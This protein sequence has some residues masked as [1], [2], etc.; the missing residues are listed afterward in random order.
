M[1]SN[2][3]IVKRSTKQSK[4]A[5]YILMYWNW[6]NR[7][8]C[9]GLQYSLPVL[10][11]FSIFLLTPNADAQVTKE[12]AELY[13]GRIHE[14]DDLYAIG[15]DKMSN[16]YVAGVSEN[17][18][19]GRDFVTVSYDPAGLR[20]WVKW[21]G[22]SPKSS[23]GAYD[24]AVDTPGNI[25]VTGVGGSY[26]GKSIDFV[27]VSYEGDGI[28]RWVAE[29]DGP[30][31]LADSARAITTGT[32]NKI[33]VTGNSE[34]SPW[35]LDY[36]TVAY[37]FDGTELWSA[38]YD[39]PLN[40]DDRAYDI[41]ADMYGNVYVTGKSMGCSTS[42]ICF[43]IVT[44]AYDS[45][46]R[47]IWEARF[48]GPAHGEDSVSEITVDNAGNVYVVGSICG[49]GTSSDFVTLCYDSVSGTLTWV[50]TYDSTYHDYDYA[51]GIVLD[52]A[53]NIYVTGLSRR[54]DTR[55]DIVTISYDSTGTQRWFQRYNDPYDSYDFGLDIAVGP[56]GTVLV[57]G[58]VSNSSRP[59][60]YPALL[61]YHPHTSALLWIVS[62]PLSGS[63]VYYEKLPNTI[64]V[65]DHNE[66]YMAARVYT[67]TGGWDILTVKCLA[68][69][70][71]PAISLISIAVLLICVPL[72][73]FS[74][75]C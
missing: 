33:Y 74:R 61:A 72:V 62:H 15:V 3:Y 54:S 34:S 39:N 75:D 42:G 22:R 8:K 17:G 30:G 18:S 59:D 12:W 60:Y 47:Q 67:T 35:N 24:L 31:S 73:E 71:I 69:F 68:E 5:E 46:G 26:P 14:F 9:N 49:I 70:R 21:Y 4:A 20:R 63:N 38:R 36:A 23:E 7:T 65:T 6:T 53:G 58:L 10:T 2:N 64:A 37:D 32:G 29:Y 13:D 11:V 56:D 51:K 19:S 28:L 16:V 40:E 55:D 27:T 48:D 43:D 45:T 44:V 1:L 50:A 66:I 57:Q 52:D 25:Y 41:V